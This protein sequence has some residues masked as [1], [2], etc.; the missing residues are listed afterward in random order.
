MY[1]QSQDRNT[2]INFDNFHEVFLDE[3]KICAR[4]F[5]MDKKITVVLGEYKDME[6]A[7]KEFDDILDDLCDDEVGIHIL[8]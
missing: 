2:L 4:Y 6:T 7:K 5:C 8:E 3:E 1:I